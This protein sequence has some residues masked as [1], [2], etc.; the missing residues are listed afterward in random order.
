MRSVK[1]TQLAVCIGKAI[2]KNRRKKFPNHGGL[3][4]CCEKYGV[5]PSQWVKWE[6][7]RS[8]PS[9]ANQAKLA[10]FFGIDLWE[11]RGDNR[12]PEWPAGY[13]PREEGTTREYSIPLVAYAAAASGVDEFDI[14]AM[15]APE[16]ALT[17][18]TGISAVKVV[19]DSAAP[20]A[21]DGQLVLVDT[22]GITPKRG[23]LVVVLAEGNTNQRILF[24]RWHGWE[25]DLLVLGSI[26]PSFP[27]ETVTRRKY[28]SAAIILGT[29][30]GT[31]RRR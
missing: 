2:K 6:S 7:G 11:L 4:L 20:V 17:I 14:D 18:P 15:I 31:G 16:E 19:G 1:N 5:V 26:N 8:T 10:K 27:P 13:D 25:G 24:K 30:Y 3:K 23:D 12:P 28:R 21:L 22:T 9:D 29:W